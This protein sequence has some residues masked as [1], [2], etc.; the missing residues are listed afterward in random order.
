MSFNSIDYRKC[1]GSFATGVTVITTNHNEKLTGITVNSFTSLSL[2]PYMILFNIGKAS[3]KYDTFKNCEYFTVNILEESQL[4]LSQSFSNP[5]PVDWEK[6]NY[7]HGKTNTPILNNVLSYLE[8]KT[9]K[10]YD[11]GDHSII[12]ARVINLESL[13]NNKPLLYYKGNYCQIND[14][15]SRDL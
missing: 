7:K 5:E 13:S 10:I 4:N 12:T 9:D 6:I 3:S 11:G 1:L 14:I 15:N 2:D 8:C